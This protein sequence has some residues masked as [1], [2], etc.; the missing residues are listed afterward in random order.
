MNLFSTLVGPTVAGLVSMAVAALPSSGAEPAAIDVDRSRAPSGGSMTGGDPYFPLDGNGG[1]QVEHYKIR[2]TYDPTKDRLTGRTVLRAV[3]GKELSR[4]HLDL[5]LAPDAV[6]V[7]GERAR[8][9]KPKS[10]ELRVV[11]SQPLAEDAAFKVRVDYHGRPASTSAAGLSPFFHQRGEGLALGEPQI[12]PWWFAANE[13]PADKATYDISVRVP[14][15]REAVSNG[16]LVSRATKGRWTTWRWEMTDPIVTY[17][18]FFLAGELKLERGVVDGRPYVYAVSKRLGAAARERSFDL[19]H[20]TPEIVSWLEEQF[21]AYPYVSVGGVIA[22]IDYLGFAL[23]NASR[24]VYPYVGGP[25][26]DE[27]IALVVHE[28]A[29]Q[30]FGDDVSVRR[31]KDLWL[32]EGFATYAEWLYAEAHGGRTVAETLQRGY[33]ARPASSSFWDLRV[34]DPGP[35]D[36][37]NAPVYQRGGMMLAALRNRMGEAE[38]ENLLRRWV[39]ERREDHGTGEEFRALAETVSGEE[40]DAFFAEWLDDTDRPARTADNGLAP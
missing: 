9:S 25:E 29:H 13:T 5:A 36:M 6:R 33:D 8:F 19:L 10:H 20:A 28:Q 26:W 4:F 38:L 11:P 34:S 30:W 12:G 24:P 21:G 35:D 18:A 14:K 27:N 2:V 1:Y 37:W 7:D 32:N 40:L 16:E 22:G 15:G 31:W 17:L 23:E 39:E 3:A